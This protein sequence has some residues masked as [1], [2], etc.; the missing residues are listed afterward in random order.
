MIRLSLLLLIWGQAFVVL[1]QPRTASEAL[2]GDGA[3]LQLDD[4]AFAFSR[5]QVQLALSLY[6]YVAPTGHLGMH[7]YWQPRASLGPVRPVLHTFVSSNGSWMAGIGLQGSFR[8]WQHWLVQPGFW[9]NYYNAGNQGGKDLGFWQQF[10]SS[11][12]VSY[13]LPR[14]LAKLGIG[15]SHISNADVAE[16]NPGLELVSIHIAVPLSLPPD[17]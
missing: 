10:K 3:P 7:L 16:L 15:F 1:G 14:S 2:H 11:I 9:A 8:F 13:I 4:P 5:H 6:D 12:A 17:Y